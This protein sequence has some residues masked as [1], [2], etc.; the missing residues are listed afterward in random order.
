MR[1]TARSSGRCTP[2]T[3]DWPASVS[4]TSTSARAMPR[5]L[6]LD[7]LGRQG[8]LEIEEAVE[9]GITDFE[10]EPLTRTLTKNMSELPFGRARAARILA[11]VPA[12][13]ALRDELLADDDPL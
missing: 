5:A 11:R 4:R 12:K 13:V 9:R 1:P 2:R 10:P 3:T 8:F 7:T 6:A